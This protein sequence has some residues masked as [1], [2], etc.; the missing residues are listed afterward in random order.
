MA[1]MA[2]SVLMFDVAT[3]HEE[4][5]REQLLSR[6]SHVASACW[7]PKQKMLGADYAPRKRMTNHS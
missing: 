1:K 4:P 3:S 7:N 2:S 6:Y 5:G